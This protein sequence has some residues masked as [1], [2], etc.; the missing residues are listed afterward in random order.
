MDVSDEIVN[1]F[2]F[3]FLFFKT[4]IKASGDFHFAFVFSSPRALRVDSAHNSSSKDLFGT[5]VK[6]PASGAFS[7]LSSH[8]HPFETDSQ[9]SWEKTQL[10]RGQ[11]SHL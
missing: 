5:R 6:L 2:L 3:F 10:L 8:G 4:R 7:A 9:K 11:P 1:I